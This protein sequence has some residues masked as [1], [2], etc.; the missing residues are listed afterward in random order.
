VGGVD[1]IRPQ[2]FLA[3]AKARTVNKGRAVMP[4]MSK[5]LRCRL[6]RHR[7]QALT[8]ADGDGYERC[9]RCGLD[10]GTPRHEP[11]EH[12]IIDAAADVVRPRWHH[13][14]QR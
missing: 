6:Y 13:G 12:L 3:C 14:Q 9:M 10:R 8:N 4:T 2:V 7:W 5:S 1:R 11:S